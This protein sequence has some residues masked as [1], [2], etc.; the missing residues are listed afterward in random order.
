MPSYTYRCEY[1][2][3]GKGCRGC[4]H[5]PYWYGYYREEGRLKKKYFGKKDPRSGPAP[6]TVP[7]NPWDAIYCWQTASEQ[8]A[9]EILGVDQAAD[10]MTCRRAYLLACKTMHPD[11]GGDSRQ[12]QFR[13]AAWSYLKALH[14][15]R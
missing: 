8:L 13:E 12:F 14:E 9:R 4:P 10:Y 1:V 3:C 5:G 15:W 6:Q 11:V 2:R 7:V